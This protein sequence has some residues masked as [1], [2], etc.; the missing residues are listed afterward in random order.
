M[1]E[2]DSGICQPTCIVY[3]QEGHISIDNLL[4]INAL[5]KTPT[6]AWTDQTVTNVDNRLRVHQ[7]RSVLHRACLTLNANDITGAEHVDPQGIFTPLNQS[8]AK[9]SC[10]LLACFPESTLLLELWKKK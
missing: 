10:A 7:D 4:T 1:E 5:T 9:L 8:K 6:L 3:K 2:K